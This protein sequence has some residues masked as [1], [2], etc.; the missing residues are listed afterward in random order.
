LSIIYDALKKVE[1]ASGKNSPDKNVNKT[2]NKPRPILII[3]FL[4]LL[5]TFGINLSNSLSKR[6]KA[7]P[8]VSSIPAVEPV[9]ELLS[10]AQ[11]EKPEALKKPA[12]VQEPILNL[13]GIFFEKKK[14]YAL[15]N[16]Q[17][18]SVK[19]TIQ[20]ATVKEISLNKVVLE[21]EGREITINS[22]SK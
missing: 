3:I 21:F 18:L 12:Q 15:I 16:N 4:I 14:G 19:D 6:P 5:I 7:K 20:G 10:P 8:A 17:I 11:E 9:Q 13:S 22:Y 1:K 2:N